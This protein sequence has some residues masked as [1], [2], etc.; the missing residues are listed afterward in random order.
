MT[1]NE[2]DRKQI[3]AKEFVI[4]FQNGLLHLTSEVVI[5]ILQ[6]PQFVLSTRFVAKSN[7]W[8]KNEKGN[9]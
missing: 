9:F 4:N 3:L 1:T 5:A 7:H 8:F 2:K 6:Q